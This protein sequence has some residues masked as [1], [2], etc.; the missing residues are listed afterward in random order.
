MVMAESC[1]YRRTAGTPWTRISQG[2]PEPKGTLISE[3]ATNEAEPSVF[4]VANN[5]GIFRS[6]DA[7]LTWQQLDVVWP[8]RYHQQ[9]V[10]A[11]AVV[12]EL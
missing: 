7:G 5:R 8:E 12:G 4:Y 3:V 11:I 6:A 9:Q 2:L 1:F 10:Q